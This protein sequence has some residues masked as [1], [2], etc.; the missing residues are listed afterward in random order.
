MSFLEINFQNI[1]KIT[2][3][4]NFQLYIATVAKYVRMCGTAQL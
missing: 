2:T 4:E 3:I 1:M